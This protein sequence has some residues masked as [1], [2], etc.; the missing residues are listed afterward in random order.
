[1][2]TKAIAGFSYAPTIFRSIG[3]ANSTS[4]ILATGIVGVVN[5]VF[6]IP[7]CLYVDN[8]GRRPTLFIG[9]VALATCL[10][11]I[12]AIVAQFGDDWAN[13][14]TAGNAAVCVKR[15]TRIFCVYSMFVPSIRLR[16]STFISRC[17]LVPGDHLHGVS[18]S[19]VRF[20][21]TVA[22][23]ITLY[24]L[25]SRL[26]GGVPLISSCKRNEASRFLLD[27]RDVSC[28]VLILEIDLDM[29]TLQLLLSNQ[30]AHELCGSD[31]Y[32]YC[33]PK[34]RLRHLYIVSRIYGDWCFVG[35]VPPARAQEQDIRTG[36]FL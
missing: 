5:F 19:A 25:D 15:H 3:L 9:S 14:E 22:D 6:T 11:I 2:L 33:A 30:L 17:L 16:S 26:N 35:L 13:N 32:T 29:S 21:R 36:E 20:R 12:A 7:A 31:G 1:M 10:A 8:W 24:S 23:P 27:F 34:H 28:F 18:P 4:G